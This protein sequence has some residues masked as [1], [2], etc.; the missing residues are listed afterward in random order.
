M[1]PESGPIPSPP[2]TPIRIGDE[3]SPTMVSGAALAEALA[4]EPGPLALLVGESPPSASEV[5]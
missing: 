5:E 4:A 2:P 1:S 3:D